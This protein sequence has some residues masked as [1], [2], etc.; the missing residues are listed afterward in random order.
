[1]PVYNED[2]MND[3][4]YYDMER[5]R[6]AEHYGNVNMGEGRNWYAPMADYQIRILNNR[7]RGESR[8]PTVYC[9]K[10]PTDEPKR[11]RAWTGGYWCRCGYRQ[12]WA[13]AE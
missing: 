1:V 5:Q 2:E 6:A 12:A 9:P 11:L 3:G 10:C 8:W 13:T 7:Q 4:G